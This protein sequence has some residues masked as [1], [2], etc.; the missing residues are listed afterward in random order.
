MLTN[1][2]GRSY[3]HRVLCQSC[4]FK[5][6]NYELKKRWDGLWVCKEDYE[7]RHPSDFYKTRNDTHKLPFIT[8]DTPADAANTFTAYWSGT[9]NQLDGE[10]MVERTG[11]YIVDDL[12]GKT[13]ASFEIYF[14]KPSMSDATISL[15]VDRPVSTTTSVASTF[16]LPTLPT[17]GGTITAITSY[18]KFAATGTVSAGNLN[19]TLGSWTA[20]PGGLTIS[21]IYGT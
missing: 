20:L 19:A 13:R 3:E 5:F 4:G 8:S 7:V 15:I 17:T 12:L 2:I 18:G 16:T 9:G 14:T 10:T 1:R 11:Y 6:W 21:A